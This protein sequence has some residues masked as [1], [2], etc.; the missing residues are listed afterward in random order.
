MIEKLLSKIYH[1]GEIYMDKDIMNSAFWE[2][3][4]PLNS[5]NYS[6]SSREL[7]F[8]FNQ[9]KNKFTFDKIIRLFINS[10]VQNITSI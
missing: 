9:F 6:E 4:E 3:L 2:Y 10:V 5:L 7:I 8:T 1:K